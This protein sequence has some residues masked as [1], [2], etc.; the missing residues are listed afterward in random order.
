M[1]QKNI[2]IVKVNYQNYIEITPG[3]R[4]GKPCLKGTR[5]SVYD[6]L[7]WL[8]SGMT[9]Q[10]IIDDYPELAAHHIQS[11]LAYAADREHHS[12]IIAA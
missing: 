5:T 11:C 2:E 4:S 9:T 10:E 3:K 12:V 1:N 8:A 7:G 6:V